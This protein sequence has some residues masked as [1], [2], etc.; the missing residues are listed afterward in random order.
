MM[1]RI[2]C[3]IV[4]LWQVSMGNVWAADIPSSANQG[5]QYPIVLVHGLFGYDS[6]FG[7]DEFSYFYGIPDT[8]MEQGH[9]VYVVQVAAANSTEVRGEELLAQVQAILAVDGAEKVNL[10]GHSHG[11]P[12]ARYVASVAPDLVASVTSVGGVNFGSKVADFIRGLVAPGSFP[13]WVVELLGDALANLLEF[14]SGSSELPTDATAALDSLTTE[15]AA[16]F[17]QHYPEGLP[18]TA[19]DQGPIIDNDVYY[20]SWSGSGHDQVADWTGDVIADAAMKLMGDWLFDDEPND[21]L[22]GTCSTHLGRVINDSYPMNH[23]DEVNQGMGVHAGDV[24]PLALFV[25]H[26]TLLKQLKL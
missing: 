25:D 21:G 7:Q 23:L 9:R 24:D 10:I 3:A 2:F 12:T 16:L 11:G 13:D 26:A 14:I 19:C 15:G 8:L 22:V 17:N 6:L 1:N 18:E 20:F 5:T 4:L